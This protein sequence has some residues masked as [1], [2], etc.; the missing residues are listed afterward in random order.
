MGGPP[1]SGQIG[2]KNLSAPNR[3]VGTVAGS[4]QG[5]ADDFGIDLVLCQTAGDVGV[6]VLNMTNGQSDLLP[7]IA[8]AEIV[9]V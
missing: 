5:Q 2:N 9:R 3:A 8:G 1:V 7:G 6:V 4:V